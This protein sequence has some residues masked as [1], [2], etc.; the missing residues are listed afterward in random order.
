MIQGKNISLRTVR[1]TDLDFYYE[2]VCD[3]DGSG[4]YE[5]YAINVPSAPEFK[6]RFYESGFWTEN[7]G[8]LLICT[9][10][11][12]A[13]GVILFFKAASYFDGF[14]V[15]YRIFN[16][17]HRNRGVM[18]EALMLFTYLLFMMKKINR[19]ELKIA[20]ANAP[21]KRVAQKCGYQFEGVARGAMFHRGAQ[22]DLE[23]HSILRPEA[24]ATLEDA[25]ARVANKDAQRGAQETK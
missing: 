21:S 16:A 1:E 3:V 14:E 2:R 10:D 5:Y 18:T 22:Q 4:Q 9:Q 20:P 13:I 12:G 8:E 19:L 25:L 23:V 17:D 24:P 6:R 11:D 15:A 7:Y